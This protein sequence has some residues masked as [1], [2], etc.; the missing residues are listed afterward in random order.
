MANYEINVKLN[1]E[2]LEKNAAKI[3][4][5]IDTLE[6]TEVKKTVAFEIDDSQ[7]K[8]E[9]DKKINR[10]FSNI[11]DKAV[12]DSLKQS[13][14]EKSIRKS[15][16]DSL[17]KI[18]Y[19][20]T[21]DELSEK[22]EKI[23]RDSLVKA[24]LRS[25]TSG[26][27]DT[28]VKL[29]DDIDEI[30]VS[31]T[32]DMKEGVVNQ[33]TKI[34]NEVKELGKYINSG[35]NLDDLISKQDMR[36]MKAIRKPE[37]LDH[38]AMIK[39]VKHMYTSGKSNDDYYKYLTKG[40]KE[41]LE[42]VGDKD[43]DTRNLNSYDLEDVM[44]TLV[45]AALADKGRYDAFGSG[46]YR[47]M[48]D[49]LYENVKKF[50]LQ[51]IKDPEYGKM[52]YG[53]KG[54]DKLLDK[55]IETD[56]YVNK[57]PAQ[58]IDFFDK[59]WRK[60]D[61]K[62]KS[63]IDKMNSNL[64]DNYLEV[65][66]NIME[67]FGN[68]DHGEIG[69]IGDR[70]IKGKKGSV[71]L[72]HN[73]LGVNFHTHPWE[74]YNN[75]S[76]SAADIKSYMWDL[77]D[78]DENGKRY[79]KEAYI[80]QKDRLFKMDFS[81][82]DWS[83]ITVEKLQ[84][85]LLNGIK[86][87]FV[88]NG[89]AVKYNDDGTIDDFM[90]SFYDQEN[91]KIEKASHEAIRKTMRKYGGDAA[92][93]VRNS[94]GQFV[95]TQTGEI[96]KANS[97]ITERIRESMQNNEAT[98]ENIGQAAASINKAADKLFEAAEMF[99]GAGE[100]KAVQ[101]G[102]DTEPSD[103]MHSGLNALDSIV[104][105][106]TGER[107]QHD[108]IGH[109]WFIAAKEKAEDLNELVKD[110]DTNNVESVLESLSLKDTNGKK[111]MKFKSP[112]TYLKSLTTGLVGRNDALTMP[113]A[114]GKELIQYA[115]AEDFFKANS[116]YLKLLVAQTNKLKET[117]VQ[118]EI[119][120]EVAD[121]IANDA[122]GIGDKSAEKIS[123]AAQAEEKA[124]EEVKEA[125]K[126]ISDETKKKVITNT[127]PT[128]E[129][130]TQAVEE[131]TEAQKENTAELKAGDNKQGY[132]IINLLEGKTSEVFS[133]IEEAVDA[134][135][136]DFKNYT[137]ATP[138]NVKINTSR[139]KTKRG[140]ATLDMSGYTTQTNGD[141]NR[142]V[143]TYNIVAA[144][145]QQLSES[146][147]EVTTDIEKADEV[148]ENH[149]K[150]VGADLRRQQEILKLSKSGMSVANIAKKF[151][152]DVEEV[153]KQL[154]E[155]S[156][157]FTL[158]EKENFKPQA[159]AIADII[160][161][162]KKSDK[163]VTTL[164]RLNATLADINNAMG[165]LES[166]YK[167]AGKDVNGNGFYSQL[168]ERKKW[169]EYAI[170]E[171]IGRREAEEK[172]EQYKAPEEAVKR[173]L[174]SS[175]RAEEASENLEKTKKKYDALKRIVSNKDY[176]EEGRKVSSA[177]V[178]DA[179]K[180]YYIPTDAKLSDEERD[181]Y[182]R[183]KNEH[184]ENTAKLLEY[185]SLIQQYTEQLRDEKTLMNNFITKVIGT[186]NQATGEIRNLLTN[187]LNTISDENTNVLQ[188]YNLLKEGIEEAD[189]LF[190]K[191]PNDPKD[192]PVYMDY[193]EQMEII[194]RYLHGGKLSKSDQ[195]FINKLNANRGDDIIKSLEAQ[196]QKLEEEMST[197]EYKENFKRQKQELKET[198]DELEKTKKLRDELTA[199][200]NEEKK[201]GKNANQEALEQY[202]KELQ[203]VNK[204]YDMLLQKEAAQKKA[205]YGK[206][207][208]LNYINSRLQVSRP[209]DLSKQRTT[210]DDW[211]AYG[212]TNQ[213]Q[214][215]KIQELEDELQKLYA[216]ENRDED[217]INK[218]ERQLI[219]QGKYAG[220]TFYG[221]FDTKKAQQLL[222]DYF[223]VIPKSKKVTGEDGKEHIV[224]NTEELYI[225]YSRDFD[226]RYDEW[227]AEVDRLK[228]E[229]PEDY[230]IP[231]SYATGRHDK[232]I[233][234]FEQAEFH[235]EEYLQKLFDESPTIKTEA[236]LEK[237]YAF[238]NSYRPFMQFVRKRSKFQGAFANKATSVIP[239]EFLDNGADMY[240]TAQKRLVLGLNER[241]RKKAMEFDSG[242]PLYKTADELVEQYNNLFE[243]L[244]G[245]KDVLSSNMLRNDRIDLL[246]RIT[247]DPDK[248]LTK[249]IIESKKAELKELSV[250]IHEASESDV[251]MLNKYADLYMELA[252]NLAD[253]D[254]VQN[255][256]DRILDNKR[257]NLSF[258][259]RQIAEY[260]SRLANFGG[261]E[262][263]EPWDKD[264]PI[265]RAYETWQKRELDKALAKKEE[266][267][268]AVFYENENIEKQIVE[269]S[270]IAATNMQIIESAKNV[271]TNYARL[272]ELV[273]EL[274][275]AAKAELLEFVKGLGVI[276]DNTSIQDLYAMLDDIAT[277]PQKYM[278]EFK[279][280]PV[281]Y[282]MSY[283]TEVERQNEQTRIAN[284]ESELA[285]AKEEY[286]NRLNAKANDAIELKKRIDA[287]REE[288]AVRAY[289]GNKVDYWSSQIQ[290]NEERIEELNKL[291]Y[292]P[293]QKKEPTYKNIPRYKTMPDEEWKP[294]KAELDELKKAP[295]Q[296]NK[297]RIDELT[298][299]LY[300]SVRVKDEENKYVPRKE[301]LK[302][303]EVNALEIELNILKTDN[304][305]LNERLLFYIKSLE[306]GADA[307]TN[308]TKDIH[309]AHNNALKGVKVEE[310]LTE[311]T[312]ED[313][314]KNNRNRYRN[315]YI[316]DIKDAL[317]Q[318]AEN[319]S[320]IEEA[321]KAASEA[322][323]AI[324]SLKSELE[325]V[326]K[327]SYIYEKL[328]K[329]EEE[330]QARV[331]EIFGQG[332]KLNEQN[333]AN[334]E[335][336]VMERSKEATAVVST[337]E[338]KV[339]D[340]DNNNKPPYVV[341][342]DGLIISSP[343]VTI[344]DT[345]KTDIINAGNV[346]LNAENI[347]GGTLKGT[348]TESKN[349][350]PI[351]HE[352]VEDMID[353]VSTLI[354]K[355]T[356]DEG[357]NGAYKRQ[358]LI[359]L[360]D[361]LE[362]FD[363][364]DR[365]DL[366]AW[367]KM[368]ETFDNLTNKAKMTAAEQKLYNNMVKL[369]S[370]II[371]EERAGNRIGINDK[372]TKLYGGIT[373]YIKP[374]YSGDVFNTPMVW[375]S[376]ENAYVDP[377]TKDKIKDDLAKKVAEKN[378]EQSKIRQ[379]VFAEAYKRVAEDMFDQMR[380]ASEELIAGINKNMENGIEYKG[381]FHVANNELIQN[382]GQTMNDLM[383]V[384]SGAFT[385]DAVIEI[386]DRA[387][388]EIKELK[389]KITASKN[390]SNYVELVDVD[391]IDK[392]IN[393]LTTT[394]YRAVR[395]S[396]GTSSQSIVD[397]VA[398]GMNA[399]IGQLREFKGRDVRGVEEYSGL[400]QKGNEYTSTIENIKE[401]NNLYERTYDTRMKILKA[402]FDPHADSEYIQ[403]LESDLKGL[404]DSI[405]HYANTVGVDESFVEKILGSNSEYEDY[406]DSLVRELDNLTDKI[407]DSMMRKNQQ[408]FGYTFEFENEVSAIKS[409]A[410]DLI[411][412]LRN[413]ANAGEDADQI[414][415]RARERVA[416]LEETFIK[417]QSNDNVTVKKSQVA[418]LLS[419][420]SELQSNTRNIGVRAEDKGRILEI[421]AM[422]KNAEDEAKNLSKESGVAD[423]RIK[424]INKTQ[425]DN[426]AAEISD[427]TTK[428][429]NL[430]VYGANA[431]A[432]IGRSLKAQI[433]A[434]IAR[435]FSLYDII[436]YVRTG[437][438][439]IKELDTAMVELRK[440][441]DGTAQ[442]YENFRK[443][444]RA[445]ASEIASTN[446]N[447]I[448]SAA[449]WARLGYS[450]RE[451]T[452]LAKDA[453]IFVNVGD[454]VDISGATD[455]MITAMK[456]FNIQAEDA[457]SIVDKF[458]EIGNHFALS[459]T[460]IGDAMQRSASVLAASNTSFD[461]SIAL[462]TAA[463]EI[464]Q[465]PEKT[466]TALRTIALRIR[467]AK[468]ELEEMGED[469]DYLVHSTAKL[470]NL[471]KGY[472]SIG[473]KYE[474]FDIME[475]ENTF[476][477]LS[478]II[479]GIGEVYDEM[480]D[481]DRTAMLEKL[482]GK[483]RSNALAAMLQN[484]KQIDNV[485]A[486]IEESEGSALRENE[487]IVDSV[488]GRITILQTSAENFW[489]TFLDTDTVKNAITLLT[490][491]LDVLT[492]IVDEVGAFGIALPVIGGAL[493][494]Q[495]GIIKNYIEAQNFLKVAN[496]NMD[497]AY[498]AY[499]IAET[500]EEVSEATEAMHKANHEI[501][502]A[503]QLVKDSNPFKVIGKAIKTH[504]VGI[505][506]ATAAIVAL[507]IA[508]EKI[509]KASAE[510]SKKVREMADEYAQ[511]T[512]ELKDYK[513]KILQIHEVLDD[514]KSTT[515]QVVN[516]KEQLNE[517]NT[518]LMNSYEGLTTS[519]D[520]A[521][522]SLEESLDLVER[523][524]EQKLTELLG[525]SEK[526][527]VDT[528]NGIGPALVDTNFRTDLERAQ[529]FFEN[530]TPDAN[531]LQ[532]L[533]SIFGQL[534]G[535]NYND[536]W[537]EITEDTQ[538]VYEQY[539]KI[540]NMIQRNSEIIT[541]QSASQSEK[542]RAERENTVLNYFKDNFKTQ[543]EN[544]EDIE[545]AYGA[546]LI[547]N[548]TTEYSALQDAQTNYALEKT[549]ENKEA[550]REAIKQMW[551]AAADED[552]TAIEAYLKLVYPDFNF[553][554]TWRF[555][556]HLD[557][558]N[559]EG[560]TRT[561]AHHNTDHTLREYLEDIGRSAGN[562]IEDDWRYAAMASRDALEEWIEQ[563]N[564]TSGQASA[565]RDINQLVKEHPEYAVA[566]L[567]DA[568]HEMGYSTT[569]N[570]DYLNQIIEG[571]RNYAIEKYG[572]EFGEVFDK[573]NIKTE[574]QVDI[575]NGL[576]EAIND[577][578]DAVRAFKLEEADLGDNLNASTVLKNMEAQ[579]KPVFDSLAEAYKAIWSTRGF[580]IEK[581]TS[582]Q[583]ESVRSNI[584]SLSTTLQEAGMDGIDIKDVDDFILK[585]SDTTTTSEEAH[586]AFNS[587]A[588][589][590]VD[591]LN[592]AMA[593]ASGETSQLMINT[594]K[595]MGVKNA[596][597]VVYSR[598]GYTVEQYAEA[599]KEAERIGFDIDD[600]ISDLDSE[601]K[602]LIVTNE[603]LMD[604]YQGKLL[605]NSDHIETT[606]D[607]ENLIELAETLGYTELGIYSLADAKKKLDQLHLYEFNMNNSSLPQQVR[608]EYEENYNAL[609]D[610][611]SQ[612][613]RANVGYEMPD[614]DYDAWFG[615]ENSNASEQDFDWIERVIK[616]IQRAV[617]N[618]GKVAD[619]TY[620]KWGERLDGVIG[621][622]DSLKQEIAIQQQAAQ[623][624]M[625]E[626]NAIGLEAEYV[627]KIQNGVMDIET[628]TNEVL[629]DQIQRYQEYYDKATDAA[630]A[631]QDLEQELANLAQ[632]R[633]DNITKQFEEMALAIDHAA[634]RIGHI[635]SKMSA[636]GLFESSTLIEQLIF[637]DKEKLG[638][639]EEEAR[640]LAASIDE[641][642]TNGDIEYGSEQWWGM[643]DSL[644]NVNDQI[645]E[646]RSSIAD[647]NDQ[648]R[649]MSW[650]NF[651]YIQDA[652][653][654]LRTEND[655]LVET[656]ETENQLFEKVQLMNSDIMVSNGN[657]TEY[658]TAIQGLHVNNLQILEKQNEE[659][660]E[661]IK[662]INAD[663][664][665]D[666]NNKK[667]LERRNELID[668]QQ[669]I[670][671]GITSEKQAIK[672]LI[673]EGYETFLDYLQKSIDKRKEALQAQKAL[674]D[675]EE[676]I[677]EQ[678][679]AIAS[680]QKQLNALSGDDSEET[681]ARL[682]QLTNDLTK[683]E[684]ELQ[685]T[686]YEQWLSDQEKMMDNMYNSFENLINLR[687]DDLEGLIE[688]AIQQTA[689]SATMIAQ[690]VQGQADEFIYGLDNTSFGVNID[691][692]MSDAI[693]AVNAV[694]DA[695]NNMINAA[696][697]NATNELAQLQA[698]A[699]TVATQAAVQANQIPQVTVITGNNGST[700]SS[701][702]GTGNAKGKASG[703]NRTYDKGPNVAEQLRNEYDE[704]INKYKY[705]LDMYVKYKDE[706][707][708]KMRDYNAN[709][710]DLA[711]LSTSV[712]KF[713]ENY[714]LFRDKANEK[715]EE[716][717]KALSSGAYAKG[718][719][720]GNAIKKSGEDGI[721]LARSGE[722]VLS[723]ERVKQMQGIFKM[724]QPL[725]AMDSK[726][727]SN[728]GNST[729]VNGMNVS[730]ALPN[731]TSYEDFV[732]K[733][734]S[735]P[736]FEKI[737][738][739]M[740]IGTSL[741][742]NKLSK[743][744]IG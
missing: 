129:K 546:K 579:Y 79:F 224:D 467:G 410:L 603:L 331:R 123:E 89:G 551:I 680:Y 516:A 139:A 426:L 145:M 604:F 517:I 635:Q 689:D 301:T 226:R 488:Q 277:N 254:Y 648:L 461:E 281:N 396:M 283:L 423:A 168:S 493:G 199:K 161:D 474:G 420:A 243:E 529:F 248:G 163:Q 395:D 291:L 236:D 29:F 703:S 577:G 75:L 334:L 732:Q 694:E 607:V 460:D 155:A 613:V 740:T 393:D 442:E 100:M 327:T 227:Q 337:E 595:E 201:K 544:L 175:K 714:L 539:Q 275:D 407:S 107:F 602:G 40:L 733:A 657:W 490:D 531:R 725:A 528:D 552:K 353:K 84:E 629:K 478:E 329:I 358:G 88:K 96:W 380:A 501:K 382:V 744:S 453:Q 658:A 575:W 144:D 349:A 292:E 48:Y 38:A 172:G 543:F 70:V 567:V 209:T 316:T 718:G 439:T 7:V 562:R 374:K 9:V 622:Y 265:Y 206:Q 412:E 247:D 8:R 626:A 322:L 437:I 486:S 376:Q 305:L 627:N 32:E 320:I 673:K 416:E 591:S 6:N 28:D 348:T 23:I 57:L 231:K 685:K 454:G 4:K 120:K 190:A 388:E 310:S 678:T 230:E 108:E 31:Y 361:Q 131:N 128:E 415:Q 520:L 717:Q 477:S 44:S 406:A 141:S 232:M 318:N 282:K 122:V 45:Q 618:F 315:E 187:G 384:V 601:I 494:H 52:W 314:E 264:R 612:G 267:T 561:N 101:R 471:I 594:L 670:I 445:T 135:K 530:G 165:Q 411:K 83:K 563:N 619:A 77:D 284:E 554:N 238:L 457:M 183:I 182:L 381:E 712:E 468:S 526:I 235:T 297:N 239:Q 608:R 296:E 503:Q 210:Y 240:A 176:I 290:A 590:L 136:K 419:R 253:P 156:E 623:A 95:D 60:V 333:K 742:K 576:V 19:D 564:F 455:M 360:K 82:I 582:E 154:A 507:Y 81:N 669:D 611:M 219:L 308:L 216:E 496:S 470:R 433:T 422:L 221:A 671:K 686:E 700:D 312:D 540:N 716:L 336:A 68:S 723:L 404:Y 449:S 132:K 456:A 581:V 487:H 741:G 676:T 599:K 217:R 151:K 508:Y 535:Y 597:A 491:L 621:K 69:Y 33:I 574:E 61:G 684:K 444:V 368:K 280:A 12:I 116:E 537:K 637:G 369:A 365:A 25:K 242:E 545:A 498:A 98:S 228:A 710:Q 431:F 549:E 64:S 479:K 616:K 472:T 731:V 681:Q 436:R 664:A 196:K 91:E 67:V 359:N 721:I 214:D 78:V 609:L 735:D 724:M 385:G 263:Y 596:E 555:E 430:G 646:M 687:L 3:K 518:S 654:R 303:E 152:M 109:D 656:L 715:Y 438:N 321:K 36:E 18:D 589:T 466:G 425:Y 113:K 173:F 162:D 181:E 295:T 147:Q 701:G 104:D 47:K 11:I 326:E 557:E 330:Y 215:K 366:K 307:V 446:S 14:G 252:D 573:L 35:V 276:T 342:E 481:I 588:T 506:A 241:L 127:K 667:I 373:D 536:I 435:Y 251:H 533:S 699:A 458:N 80:A 119:T 229:L 73:R 293:V 394:M 357:A 485:I 559:A 179:N 614:I 186:S 335:K 340:E 434:Q 189:R 578:T 736:T 587:I 737:V 643:Y 617:T 683:A 99:S 375:S 448:Q 130:L 203:K 160:G 302:R 249:D 693:Y 465:D 665:N 71:R 27:H 548:Y 319:E 97:E 260:Q 571:A 428:Y 570:E 112:R 620:K 729:T 345:A 94:S 738:Q 200:E 706:L 2:Q 504:I 117:N 300:K 137:G 286:D 421:V 285:K 121:K 662:K 387:Q 90:L 66:D 371:V 171:A 401:I 59:S 317:A 708:N 560:F 378:A 350:S 649:Q 259:A 383:D 473:G 639:L 730:F 17:N 304:Q 413:I 311:L 728:L 347:T 42:D 63:Y 46:N 659:V 652:V 26:K 625:A 370:E 702:G 696:N 39:A 390:K 403:R 194:E 386:M 111:P 377:K 177:F 511:S 58:D 323:S 558:Y 527:T 483:N 534:F 332:N 367:S 167:N 195:E 126:E 114:G 74:G 211:A 205:T 180:N 287:E 356:T 346:T 418:S 405:K 169:V 237:E 532:G 166:A 499:K 270:E 677:S 679:K 299:L 417:V 553:F 355:N 86:D 233:K 682:Q 719:T 87:A 389:S 675:Y 580:N 583:L 85:E 352:E 354:L 661:E 695:I 234:Y 605:A 134:A 692:R 565:F 631:V 450:I 198:Q 142:F 615:D 475:D 65:F 414:I 202:E 459:A 663:L 184:D 339:S 5:Y 51:Y 170:Q 593:D 443:E 734:K 722:E 37:R 655:F 16:T 514:E 400:V 628:V 502:Q 274:S 278:E 262:K 647:L 653:A 645:V 713:R 220:R 451:A 362:K 441:T 392:R 153:E 480:S 408:G 150:A 633:F 429:K 105:P 164:D 246:D 306:D 524:N 298:E 10:D 15:I 62:F 743:Y 309:A 510:Y 568:L 53:E 351:S 463:N 547:K 705:W 638:Q 178:K 452:E 118:G 197:K 363:K 20:F 244:T 110:I 495:Y 641:A 525:S 273:G 630:D 610:E 185:E 372:Y 245:V 522:M 133:T 636:E 402:K 158:P 208:T 157:K 13:K 93:A 642:V 271:R 288:L 513:N 521:N 106:K 720:I 586:E 632:T 523:L 268:Q 469:T 341:P 191:V 600:D 257:E 148:I 41:I 519:I 279:H 690:T 193:K 174:D 556:D 289:L 440:V 541:S 489:Q 54:Y 727:I 103:K 484:Y 398:S 138:E 500:A 223:Q 250:K 492:K 188:Y 55:F 476:K 258:Y 379:Q 542:R 124:A 707:D 76:P 566:D 261:V 399:H 149:P 397:S 313:I 447:L 146:V 482:A 391:T 697:V 464:L 222:Y 668:Q 726:T 34:R 207:N 218:L 624:Y 213:R 606:E 512:K 497:K 294:L 1:T 709:P 324:D 672:D 538:N 328:S 255:L 572:E 432:K 739:S 409:D 266:E 505:T 650:D 50:L 704:L 364:G 256:P 30:L 140:T 688:Q 651:D 550:L 343:H 509:Y 192:S 325:E 272:D 43:V 584:E 592:P 427:L 125:A 634:T 711:S 344:I 49:G 72:P 698:L 159:E 102:G 640:A 56:E 212:V 598:L 674:Y 462:I 204:Q 569:R 666:P 22:D 338:P 585:L 143:Q 21:K 115:N 691:A 660:A 225:A 424:S 24:L 92:L 515:A 644:Q 269:Q